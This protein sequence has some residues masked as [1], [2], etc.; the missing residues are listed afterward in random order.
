VDIA[1]VSGA[2]VQITGVKVTTLHAAMGMSVVVRIAL[3][4]GIRRYDCARVQNGY[5]SL[6]PPRVGRAKPADFD[7]RP[8]Q[9]QSNQVQENLGAG[10]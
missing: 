8:D 9:L 5:R 2:D 3:L 6:V 1:P 7:P 4:I 10:E